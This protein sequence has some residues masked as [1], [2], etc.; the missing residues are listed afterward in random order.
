MHRT[1]GPIF[2]IRGQY[3]LVVPSP[4]CGG[5]GVVSSFLDSF[6]N[7]S[8]SQRFGVRIGRASRR[9]G[10]DS[11][12]FGRRA[13][14][15]KALEDRIIRVRSLFYSRKIWP[16]KRENKQGDFP[17]EWPYYPIPTQ[18]TINYEMF[19]VANNPKGSTN[20]IPTEK[21]QIK[22]HY[23]DSRIFSKWASRAGA[24]TLLDR[25]PMRRRGRDSA[26]LGT[27][28]SE[29]KEKTWDCETA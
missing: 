29:E 24:Q 7:R 21:R 11:D 9:K 12:V 13:V 22:E 5:R 16:R 6:F 27:H 8:C 18:V 19:S 28:S 23:A 14:F 17:S 20:V 15:S 1:E 2:Q 3:P 26:L 4:T 25:A 10:A